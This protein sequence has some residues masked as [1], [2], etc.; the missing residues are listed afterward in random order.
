M[1]RVVTTILAIFILFTGQAQLYM[2]NMGIRAGTQVDPNAYTYIV[3]AG[4]TNETHVQAVSWLVKGEKS[5]GIWTDMLA[6]YPIA[7][8]TSGSHAVNLKNPGTNNLTFF[9]S[10]TH[11]AT[12]VDGNG[13]TQY[14]S[15]GIASSGVVL[16]SQVSLEAYI[17][18]NVSAPTVLWG[19]DD[20]TRHYGIFPNYGGTMYDDDPSETNGRLQIATSYDT[21]GLWTST[22]TATRVH[23]MYRNGSSIGSNTSTTESAYTAGNILVGARS[24]VPDF[25]S[26]RIISWFAVY[27]VGLTSTKVGQHYTLIQAYQ[28]LM[29]RPQ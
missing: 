22:Q 26:D 9:G 14:S 24:T 6:A 17:Q 25:S 5:Y 20:G 18:E 7:G 27:N 16:E 21:R 13:T 15:T 19:G 3:A 23:T 2:V 29:G 1:R 28:T 8:G 12:G 10:P 11:S 4:L